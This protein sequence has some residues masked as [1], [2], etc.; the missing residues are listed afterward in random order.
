MTISN[1]GKHL[2]SIDIARAIAALGVFAYHQ[3]WGAS[4]AKYSGI[5]LLRKIDAFGSLYA[6]PLFF[7]ISGYCIHLSN[8]KYLK[9]DQ[10]LPLKDYYKRRL[11]R[12]YPAYF[13]AVLFS[14]AMFDVKMQ[15]FFLLK[16]NLLAHLLLIHGFTSKYFLGL[17]VALWTIGVE[18]AL[19]ALYPIFYYL[20]FKF[21]LNFALV[22]TLLISCIS[23]A[24][25]LFN[26]NIGWFQLYF[27]TNLWF[28]WCC[29]AF[30]ADKRNFNES[31]LKKPVYKIIYAI[32]L[33]IFLY[34][35]IFNSEL[36]IIDY[37]FRIL[38]W[39]APLLYLLSKEKWLS[40]QK[41]IVIRLLTVIGVSSYSLYLLHEP[42]IALKNICVKAYLPVSLHNTGMVLGFLII[43][44]ITW[45]SYKFFEKP[46][47]AK[48][49][50]VT[51]V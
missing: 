12:I 15:H 17:N 43:P 44:V 47:M 5:G 14:L 3:Y 45:Y 8:I 11:F 31:A 29:G 35:Q 41:S 28:V 6:V 1:P 16:K 25:F 50:K 21:S 34:F 33:L 42:L 19:Y 48:K 30:L 9:A 13:I 39:T 51:N 2:T 38:F 37:Q 22:F 7:L 27:F 36:T 32:I 18:V 10:P 46:F 24:Y 26:G 23:T 4:L 40:Q 49:V 20:R